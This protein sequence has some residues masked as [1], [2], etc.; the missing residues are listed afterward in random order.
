MKGRCLLILLLILLLAGCG[1]ATGQTSVRADSVDF[2]YCNVLETDKSD[3]YSG[4]T[5]ALGTEL[6]V[7]ENATVEQLLAQYVQGP[8][9]PG[10]R[11]PFPADLT[12][13]TCSVDSGVLTVF[14]GETWQS[15]AGLDKT[16]AQACLIYTMTQLP[17]VDAVRICCGIHDE[18]E[19]LSRDDF[20]LLDDAAVDDEKQD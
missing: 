1:A 4:T 7:A 5:G 14:F 12:V 18:G 3:H 20:L 6:W 10:L 11:S 9:T 8:K 2:Y 19:L 15:L 17:E 16:L 13:E